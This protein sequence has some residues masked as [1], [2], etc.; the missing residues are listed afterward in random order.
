MSFDT[1]SNG[2]IVPK[3]YQVFVKPTE[4]NISQRKVE[5]YKQVCS[6]I[7]YYRRNPVKFVE[8][9]LGAELL[10][11]QAYCLQSTWNT[12][13][14]LWV[15]SRGFGKST[16][17]DLFIMAKGM[18]F[19]NYIAYIASG[20]G[21]Q[22]QG[23]FT[24]LERIAKKNIES[25]TGLTDYFRQ[26]VEVNNATGDGFIHNPDGFYYHLYNGSMLKTLNSSVDKRRGSRAN[27]VGKYCPF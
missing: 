26:E 21:S 24:T 14:S 4:K 25:M 22:S 18:L 15:C 1:T 5:R 11:A 23:T 2:I 6:F 20:S 3:D 9:I 27:L 16:L 7:N 19:S 12:P 17:T 8:E 10:D 13:N